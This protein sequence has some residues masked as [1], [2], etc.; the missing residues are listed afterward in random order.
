MTSH[1][2]QTIENPFKIPAVFISALLIVQ[3]LVLL[4]SLEFPI[5]VF[6]GLIGVVVL[7]LL[8]SNLFVG[9]CVII[10][11]HFLVLRGSEGISIGE[12]IFALCFFGYLLQWFFHKFFIDRSRLLIM[13]A[14]FALAG[15]LMLCVFSIVP[16]FLQQNEMLKWLRELLPFF[17]LLLVFPLRELANTPRRM[18]IIVACFV[19]LGVAVAI[20]NLLAYR[21]AASSVTYLWELKSSRKALNAPMFTGIIIVASAFFVM[22]RSFRTRMLALMAIVVFTAALVITF[23]RGYWLA[24]VIGVA[25]FFVLIPVAQKM[26]MG[27]YF[28]VFVLLF[29][30]AVVLFFGD[31]ANFIWD[32]VGERFLS[33]GEAGKDLSLLNRMAEAKYVLSQIAINPVVGYGL[34]KTFKYPAI[35]PYE[36]PTW[37]VHNTILFVWFKVGLPGL[38]CLLTFAGATFVQGLRVFRMSSNA[39][40][41]TLSVG[42]IACF[43]ALVF[44]SFS[45]PQLLERDSALLIALLTGLIQAEWLKLQANHDAA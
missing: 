38:L 25:T 39:F 35:I 29:A 7:F 15:F 16:A 8:F 1:P 22:V 17:T 9:L 24:T 45:S 43:V 2:S 40:S 10:L 44:V 41:K 12:V 19:L 30:G 13:P 36:F 37:Y 31:L 6:A 33:V 5:E 32:A 21:D 3:A 4:V 23:T 34:G 14:D 11:M 42:L 27:M 26:R 20:D 28:S 18:K